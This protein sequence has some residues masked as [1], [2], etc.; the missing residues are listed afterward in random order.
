MRLYIAGQR[1]RRNEIADGDI[2]LNIYYYAIFAH[3]NAITRISRGV[4]L[5]NGLILNKNTENDCKIP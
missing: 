2:K 4:T 5:R 1:L 3:K